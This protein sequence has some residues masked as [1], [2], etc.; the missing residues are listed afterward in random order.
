MSRRW[1]PL[2]YAVRDGPLKNIDYLIWKGANVSSITANGYEQPI[3]VVFDSSL[4]SVSILHRAFYHV[5]GAVAVCETLV[6]CGSAIDATDGH[7]DTPLMVA[8]QEDRSDMVRLL[9]TL[10]ADTSKTN[11]RGWNV[12]QSDSAEILQLLSE[13]SK[14]TVISIAP[15]NADVTISILFRLWN[16]NKLAWKHSLEFDPKSVFA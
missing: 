7:G 1:T 3:A 6:A 13:H 2:L 8:V 15:P 12:S 4:C 5:S 11:N 14:K 10:N 16:V 9:L